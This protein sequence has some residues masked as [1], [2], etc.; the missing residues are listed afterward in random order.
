MGQV[1]DADFAFQ[2]L[3]N[4]FINRASAKMAATRNDSPWQQ[5]LQRLHQIR[6]PRPRRCKAVHQYILDHAAEINAVVAT[7][8]TNGEKLDSCQLMNLRYKVAQSLLESKDSEFREGLEQKAA[9]QHEAAKEE[10]NLILED[11]SAAEDV[12]Q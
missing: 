8:H 1:I 11:I 5:L 9:A 4:W 12:S 3:K 10:W 7:R 2:R 6:N